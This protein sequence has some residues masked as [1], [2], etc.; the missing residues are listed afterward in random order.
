MSESI[1]LIMVSITFFVFVALILIIGFFAATWRR[2]HKVPLDP[3]GT[4]ER[5]SERLSRPG[6]AF[7]E[8]RGDVK[9]GILPAENKL[10][11]NDFNEEDEPVK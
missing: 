10:S 9:G 5:N 3:D 7:N 8:S 11:Q 2:K 4:I 6:S 1:N